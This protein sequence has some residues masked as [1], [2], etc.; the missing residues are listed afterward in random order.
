MKIKNVTD[1]VI[2]KPL[3]AINVFYNNNNIKKLNIDINNQI[4]EN[5]CIQYKNIKTGVTI[6]LFN[7][8][9]M[10]SNISN[11][12]FLNVDAY[13]YCSINNN[14]EFKIY[15]NNT[16]NNKV[17]NCTFNSSY[18]IIYKNFKKYKTRKILKA[19]CRTNESILN[20]EDFYFPKA[21]ANNIVNTDISNK[22]KYINIIFKDFYCINSFRCILISLL[23]KNMN[24]GHII[25]LN[26]F[27]FIL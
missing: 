26:I 2:N 7:I 3:Y 15:F 5:S 22:R 27:T 4:I 11:T 24:K 19:F 20:F 18:S 9:R 1:K 23:Y 6:H 13:S 8:E 10:N 21:K 17:A 25:N 12:T 16:F 14:L